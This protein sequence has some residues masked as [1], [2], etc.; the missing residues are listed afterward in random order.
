VRPMMAN[1]VRNLEEDRIGI[2]EGVWQRA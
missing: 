1:L 2:V